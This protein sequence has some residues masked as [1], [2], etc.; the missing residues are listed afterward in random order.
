MPSE[1]I[2]RQARCFLPQTGCHSSVG[3]DCM[4]EEGDRDASDKYP[5]HAV[6]SRWCAV[7]PDDLPMAIEDYGLIGDC[8]TAAL[9]SRHGSIDWLCWPRF[10]GAA[11]FAALLGQARHGRWAIAPEE[12]GKTPEKVSIT[13]RYRDDTLVLE[14]VF[15]TDTGEVALIDFMPMHPDREDDGSSLIRIVEGRKGSVEMQMHLV[16]RFDYGISVPWVMHLDD[17]EGITAIA[18]PAMTVL[19]TPVEIEGENLASIARFTVTEGRKIPFVLSYGP[20]HLSP[21][22][23]LDAEEELQHT[24]A[25]WHEWS[26]QCTYEGP[27]RDV[28]QRSLITLK[29]LTYAPTGGIVAAA[30]TSLPEEIGGSRNWDYRYCWLRDSTLTLFALMHG[31][32]RQEAQEWRD[33]LHRS[34]AGKAEQ[35]QIM[36]G[37]AGE[38]RLDEWSVPWLPGYE[39]SS[40]VRIG[41]GAAGQLQLDVYGEVIDTLY[42]ARERGLKVP[43]SSW[44]LEKALVKYLETIWQEPD[45]GLWEVRGGRQH[46]TFSKAMVWLAFDRMVLNAEH[47]GLEGPVDHWRALRDEVHERVCREGFNKEMNS[48]VQYFGG[49]TLDASLLVLPLIGFLPATDPR[50]VGTVAAIEQNLLKDG[51]VY[52]YNTEEGTDGLP[53]DEGAFLVCTFWL[54]DN[55]VLQGRH[56]EATRM[57][58]R[59]LAIQSDLGL[60][61]EEYDPHRKRQVGNF[62]Q[63]FSHVGL[64]ATILNIADGGPA[65]QRQERS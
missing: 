57:L 64:I 63:A 9:V 47:F 1:E 35:I 18:G 4:K 48:F 29:A 15:T 19:R 51:F 37:L 30:T 25:W 8:R 14:T 17:E 41:N 16:L 61:A 32:H 50:M 7:T 43:A 65:Y 23:R 33:W 42:Q 44:S 22:V 31:G 21:P 54:A 28:M 6:F 27:W 24:E 11:C 55:Y 52:R 20:S 58:E 53:G 60:F 5:L 46:F 26:S 34:I 38:R 56:D 59:L 10:D 12:L 3:Q 40:P 36:Y 45:E 2:S 62:P 49:D 13:R 39:N